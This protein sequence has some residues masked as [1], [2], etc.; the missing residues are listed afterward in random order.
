VD[1]QP[2][3]DGV[4]VGA[5]T[6]AGTGVGGYVG[7][8]TGEVDGDGVVGGEIVGGGVVGIGAVGVGAGTGGCIDMQNSKIILKSKDMESKPFLEVWARTLSL[9]LS[10]PAWS[11]RRSLVRKFWMS[12]STYGLK[13]SSI[14][15]RGETRFRRVIC[16][17][18]HS[19]SKVTATI[20]TKRI[21]ANVDVMM[22]SVCSA[23]QA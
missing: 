23:E 16:P 11:S 7:F 4:V 14:T 1:S 10:N 13:S 9:V 22:L 8:V 15:K 2:S 20:T 17:S 3:G 18:Q 19:P 12:V 21:R 6:G 5:G